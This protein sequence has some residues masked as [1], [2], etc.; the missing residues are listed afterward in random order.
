MKALGP[1]AAEVTMGSGGNL[2][3]EPNEITISAGDT[4]TFVNG[5]A[6]S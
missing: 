3:F 5:N 4:V 6:T 1:T 2:I